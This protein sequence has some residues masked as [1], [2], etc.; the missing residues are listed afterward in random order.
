VSKPSFE[1]SSRTRRSVRLGKKIFDLAAA[2]EALPLVRSIAAD[3]IDSH[4]RRADADLR[5]AKAAD[6]GDKP[7]NWMWEDRR[8][9]CDA[10]IERLLAEL[11]RIHVHVLQASRG[12]LGFPSI[13]NGALAYLVLRPEDDELR[14]WRYVDQPRL[15]DI[16]KSW[17]RSPV[18]A[19][20]IPEL[21]LTGSD[22]E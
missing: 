1:E 7:T 11:R 21:L 22:A 18:A 9:E 13:V 20:P 14:F 16:P 10:E 2:R 19:E 5:A 12:E 17:Y 15:R 6:L 3:L 4:V 8:R